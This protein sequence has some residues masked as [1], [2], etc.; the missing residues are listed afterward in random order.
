VPYFGALFPV[1]YFVL[2]DLEA[3]SCNV[4]ENSFQIVVQLD[5]PYSVF[6]NCTYN[7]RLPI[8]FLSNVL[9]LVLHSCGRL[10]LCH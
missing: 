8:L 6:F 9:G 2:V 3:H 1:D 4:S 7:I 10:Y 5:V